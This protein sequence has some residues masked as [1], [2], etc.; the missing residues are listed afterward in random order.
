MSIAAQEISRFLPFPFAD[1]RLVAINLGAML[2]F[3]LP[4]YFP[5]GQFPVKDAVADSCEVLRLYTVRSI[6]AML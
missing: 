1:R 6:D 3:L 4:G 5:S 2:V